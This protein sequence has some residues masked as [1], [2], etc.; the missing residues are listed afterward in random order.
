MPIG[1]QAEWQSMET[2]NDNQYSQNYATQQVCCRPAPPTDTF[3]PGGTLLSVGDVSGSGTGGYGQ[4]N[5]VGTVAAQCRD[6]DGT[7][8]ETHSYTCAASGA[9]VAAD[10]VWQYSSNGG[11]SCT[12]ANTTTYGACSTAGVG[13]Y[14][15]ELA[16]VTNCLGQVVSQGYTGPSCYTAPP[17]TPSYSYACQ[18]SSYVRTDNNGCSSPAIVGACT[19]EERTTNYSCSLNYNNSYPDGSNCSISYDQCSTNSW[20]C[21]SNC[22]SCSYSGPGYE[23]THLSG[24]AP[25]C[26]GS[27]GDT[28]PLNQ[29]SCTS[30]YWAPP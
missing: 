17:C 4:L 22:G 20:T 23:P 5:S 16:T 26:S 24:T 8:T 28:Q 2:S 1:S 3:C 15:N 12:S 29:E 11:D 10:G 9:G 21:S 18:G 25:G 27:S 6:P 19:E 14:G 30:T 13:G 7:Y